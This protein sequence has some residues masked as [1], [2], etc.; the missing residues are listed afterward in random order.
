M[1]TTKDIPDLSGKTVIVTGGN[2]GIGYEAA[3]QLAGKGAKT[4]LACR[5]ATRGREAAVRV[6]STFPNAAV[7]FLAL[8]LASLA[9]I[10]AFA[11]AFQEKYD[12]LHILCNNAGVMAL[13]YRKTVDG[14]EMQIGTNHLGHFALTGLL[15]E[16]LLRTPGARVINVSSTA[17]RIGKM[18]FEDLHSER[19]YAKWLAYGQ[20]K[21]ANLLF[22]Y[23]L[24]R[25]LQ[26]G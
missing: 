11:A 15:L 7:D 18:N 19:R 8:D 22:T 1:W 21:L 23:E 5:D 17:H 25:R 9:S 3:A 6:K 20:S 13:P 10:R 14:F 4:I 2:S 26:A 12:A 16:R 24:H